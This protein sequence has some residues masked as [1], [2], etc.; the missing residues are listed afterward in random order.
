MDLI[1]IVSNISIL[2]LWW[3]FLTVLYI[4]QVTV[5]E[6]GKIPKLHTWEYSI[7]I[8]QSFRLWR[9]SRRVK[10]DKLL[11][12]EILMESI[13]EIVWTWYGLIWRKFRKYFQLASKALIRKNYVISWK[14][15]H[16]LEKFSA[17]G[18]CT[19]WN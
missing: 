10:T 7:N 13:W 9:F 1:Y 5:M 15:S 2:S 8:W 12:S 6:N 17:H 19:W 4:I 14:H 11:L 3:F 18:T 16:V